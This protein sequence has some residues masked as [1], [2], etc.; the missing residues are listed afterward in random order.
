MFLIHVNDL[1]EEVRA[2]VTTFAENTK[3]R[4]KVK[5]EQVCI[6][7][8]EGLDRVQESLDKWLLEFNT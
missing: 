2:F 6:I 7:L 5:S 3:L 8:L 4:S 1:P